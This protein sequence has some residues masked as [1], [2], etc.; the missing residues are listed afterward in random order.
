MKAKAISDLAQ[1]DDQ[2]LFQVVAEGMKFIFQN[3]QRLNSDAERLS[4]LERFHG[5]RILRTIAEEEAAKLLILI[6]AVRCPRQPGDRFS[7]QLN[8][9]KDHLAKGLY[10]KS[11][12]WRPSTPAQLQRYLDFEREDFYLDG[13][14]DVDW[15]FRNNIMQRRE[16]TLYVDYIQTE[17]GHSW[18]HPGRFEKDI[19]LIHKPAALDIADAFCQ[20]GAV[21]AKGLQAIAMLWRQ[22][23][24]PMDMKWMNLRD[25]NRATMDALKSNGILEPVEPAILGKIID[26][27]QFPL[28]DLDLGVI[29]VDQA[30][31]RKRQENWTPDY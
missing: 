3:A 7:K 2:A 12:Y 13:P 5:S 6:D 30:Q 8:R 17:E 10:A 29:K 19:V 31:L 20:C 26:R 11:A 24:I 27:W 23:S 22:Q 14:N 16:E 15:I 28:Y 9:F 4:S 18:L 21:T 1:L 25:L